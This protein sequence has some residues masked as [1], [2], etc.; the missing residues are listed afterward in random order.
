MKPTLSVSVEAYD[1]CPLHCPSCPEG[2]REAVHTLVMLKPDML[3]RIL[4]RLAKQ[5]EMN[6]VCLFHLGEPLLNPELPALVDVAKGYS[7]VDISTSGD[8]YACDLRELALSQP[9]ALIVS[10]AGMSQVV[11]QVTRV[12]GR[13]DKTFEFIRQMKELGT[14]HLYIHWHR[15]KHNMHEEQRARDFCRGLGIGFSAVWG[16]QGGV[17]AML[18][19]EDNP[20]SWASVAQQLAAASRQ[21]EFPCPHIKQ[22]LTITA[23][24]DVYFCGATATKQIAGNVLEHSVDEILKRK[25]SYSLCKPC[26]KRGVYKLTCG[27][28]IE[29]DHAHARNAGG[30]TG[31]RLLWWSERARKQFWI[32]R[33]MARFPTIISRIVQPKQWRTTKQYKP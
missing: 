25:E 30:S 4:S 10:V 14:R 22:N 13:I 15:Y 29:A 9:D 5:I 26:I 12:N 11:H 1:Y 24:A 20:Q 16:Y 2:R 27:Q 21:A 6:R 8:R 28:S 7:R 31:D 23:N 18:R 3:Q 17:E 19:N 33:E 32:R